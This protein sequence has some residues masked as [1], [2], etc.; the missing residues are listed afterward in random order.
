MTSDDVILVVRWKDNN[1]ITLLS[2]D[3]GVN[4]VTKCLRY[5]NDTKKK[6]EVDCPSVIKLYNANIGGIQKSD[7]FVHLYLTPMKSKRW[8][9]RLFAYCMDRCVCN[10]WLSYWGD[11]RALGETRDLSLKDFRLEISRSL[12]SKK[13]AIQ[14]WSKTSREASPEGST[15][16]FEL[17]RP[18]RGQQSPTPDASVRFNNYLFHVLCYQTRQ[19]C[20]HCC[21]KGHTIRSNFVCLV[22][23]VHLCLSAERNC[24]ENYHEAVT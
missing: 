15:S 7:M 16:T 13:P 23:K 5:S 20:K 14:R 12:S 21:R 4:P 10:A 8:Y 11:Y 9:M 22:C 1:I 3:I 17:P 18:I 6:E 24:F 2:T 19:T